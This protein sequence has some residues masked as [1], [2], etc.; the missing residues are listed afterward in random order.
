MTAPSLQGCHQLTPHSSSWAAR[1]AFAGSSTASTIS[2][3]PR[4]SGDDSQNPRVE[5]QGLARQ[6]A[7]VSNDVDRRPETYVERKAIRDSGR[8]ICPSRSRRASA[9]SGCGV[10][11]GRSTSR[12]CP[13]TSVSRFARSCT[14][15]PIT[16]ETRPTKRSPRRVGGTR[17]RGRRPPRTPS[18]SAAIPMVRG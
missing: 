14:P 3:T 7:P 4:R 16:C 9:T 1:P 17:R 6:A 11:I 5:P 15:S 12:R 13:R 2:S 18:L 10:W 8:A